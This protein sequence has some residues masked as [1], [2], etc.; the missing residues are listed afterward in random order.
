MPVAHRRHAITLHHFTGCHHT[1]HKGAIVLHIV[2]PLFTLWIFTISV[3]RK[4]CHHALSLLPLRHC[5]LFT[6]ICHR[7]TIIADIP[8]NIE[9]LPLLYHCRLVSMLFATYVLVCHTIAISAHAHGI[10]IG[11]RQRFIEEAGRCCG[12]TQVNGGIGIG[13]RYLLLLSPPLV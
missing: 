10:L 5:L 4:S 2:T 7:H 8:F 1:A 13:R 9:T 11:H 3:G 6:A 12:A